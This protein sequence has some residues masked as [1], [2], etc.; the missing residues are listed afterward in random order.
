MTHLAHFGIGC[1]VEEQCMGA[2]SV[3]LSGTAG[4]EQCLDYCIGIEGCNF[5]THYEDL[6]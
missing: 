6:G 4:P 3:G 2:T 5:F 1:F